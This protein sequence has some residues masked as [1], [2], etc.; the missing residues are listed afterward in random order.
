MVRVGDPDDQVLARADQHAVNVAELDRCDRG[1][2]E[3]EQAHLLLRLDVP[4]DDF[5]L[6]RLAACDKIATVWRESRLE[7]L[8]CVQL[9]KRASEFVFKLALE[10]VNQHDD[11]LRR[12]QQDELPVRTELHLLDLGGPVLI[13]DREDREGA[14]L[15][16][17]CVEQV[18]LLCR[19]WPWL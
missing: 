10:R 4:N 6:G 18:D 14:L 5:L 2:M 7:D 13:V 3:V 17:L 19:C 16:V 1:G 12:A 8:T 9:V 11:V 15:V